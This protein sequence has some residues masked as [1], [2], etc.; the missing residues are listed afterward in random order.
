MDGTTKG[1]TVTKRKTDCL[2][3][4]QLGRKKYR[5]GRK[6]TQYLY[7]CTRLIFEEAHHMVLN[8]DGY[9]K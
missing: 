9:L 5:L 3:Y 4:H 6:E 2:K 8:L 1:Y 7:S